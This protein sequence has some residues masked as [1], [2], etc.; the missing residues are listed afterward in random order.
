M[1]LESRQYYRDEGPRSFGFGP[2][3]SG[4]WTMVTI[5]IVINLAFFLLDAFTPK[6]EN[7][8]RWLSRNMAIDS[9]Q[10]WKFWTLLTHGFAHASL[11]TKHGFWHVG[12]NMLA[13]FFL[14]RSVEDR[15]GRY[16]F[17]KFYLIS[18]VLS[19][20]A[21]LLIRM[22]MGKQLVA[23]GASGAVSAV[24]ALFVFMYPR[25]KVLL[26]FAIPIP[27]WTLGI[28]IV[29]LDLS[30]AFSPDSPIAWEAHLAGFAFGAAY[31]QMKWNFSWMKFDWLTSKFSNKPRLRVH[32]PN[33]GEEKLKQ[34]A[35][36]VLAKISEFGEESL[37][38]KE[39]KILNRYSAK[40]RK[41]Q[42]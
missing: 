22:G 10:P 23:V 27:A 1:G 29:L 8:L 25:V 40:L 15:L 6:S 18:I 17:L 21:L 34:Q 16:E 5:L 4:V 26:F 9:A 36:E 3:A 2:S 7:G 11:G 19:G 38:N 30:R 39:R 32:N 28:L 12:G 14:G 37:S 42:D 24:V 35:D 31:F 20:T 13:L 41:S 33:R